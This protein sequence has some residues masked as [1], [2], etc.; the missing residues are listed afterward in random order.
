VWC[1]LQEVTEAWSQA[2]GPRAGRERES[3]NNE[4]EDAGGRRVRPWDVLSRVPRPRE[5]DFVSEM[6]RGK[7]GRGLRPRL[8]LPLQRRR[9]PHQN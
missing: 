3:G 4:D 8:L 9:L 2:P 5:S 7:D 1:L 6:E